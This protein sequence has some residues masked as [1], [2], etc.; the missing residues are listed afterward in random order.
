MGV[1]C[2]SLYVACARPMLCSS[3]RARFCPPCLS[4][5]QQQHRSKLQLGRQEHMRSV[6]WPL[7]IPCGFLVMFLA[8]STVVQHY[9][10]SIASIHSDGCH[11]ML[12]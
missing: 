8:C 3:R 4:C 9:C 10:A 1:A 7:L 5:Y 12:C 11:M 6:A 2:S